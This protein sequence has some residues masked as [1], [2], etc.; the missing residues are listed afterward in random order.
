MK[1]DFNM[2]LV[3]DRKKKEK[4]FLL[5]CHHV[6]EKVRSR[7]HTYIHSYEEKKNSI[8]SHDLHILVVKLGIDV[9]VFF[10]FSYRPRAVIA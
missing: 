8:H 4:I 7:R 5:K 1:S 9:I 6:N 3:F 10:V 2:N